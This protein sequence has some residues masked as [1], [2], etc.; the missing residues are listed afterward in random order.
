MNRCIRRNYVQRESSAESLPD[1]ST[2]TFSKREWALFSLEYCAMAG[3]TARLFFDSVIAFGILLAGL[4]RYLK[5][6]KSTCM[7]KRRERLR[8]EYREFLGKLGM[9]LQ[10]GYSVENGIRESMQDMQIIYGEHSL[11]VTELRRF[12]REIRNQVPTENLLEDLG[13]RSGVPEMEE[14]A[15]VYKVARVSGGNLTAIIGRTG[16]MIGER[17]DVRRDIL[18]GLAAKRLEARLMLAVPYFIILYVGVTSPGYF[19]TIY[20]NLPGICVSV[21]CL[22]I[23]AI[24]SI[25]ILKIVNIEV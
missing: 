17:M 10:C 22:I 3:L 4:H 21:L 7:R 20:H 19:E 12:L 23:Y 25:S 9:N 24:A 15:A 2:H 13:R 6:R 1:Y 8:N 16:S 18:T 14:F 11:M 5:W